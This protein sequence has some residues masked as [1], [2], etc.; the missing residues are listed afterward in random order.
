MAR[1]SPA[2]EHLNQD[3]KRDVF[4]SHTSSDKL[5]YVRPL[6]RKLEER[7]ITY[8]LDEAEIAW[9]ERVSMAISRGLEASRYVLVVISEEFVGRT[10]PQ[11]ELSVS[12]Q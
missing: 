6:A 2:T 11:T 5:R 1:Q 10:W 3:M 12:N 4:L 8:W 9:G 7:G